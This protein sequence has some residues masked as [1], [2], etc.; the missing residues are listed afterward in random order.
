VHPIDPSP[1]ALQSGGTQ[2]PLFAIADHDVAA[3]MPLAQSLT[4][5]PLYG[6]SGV[7]RTTTVAIETLAE[8]YLPAIR[9][10]QPRGPYRLVGQGIGG[11]IAYDLAYRLL[12]NDEAVEFLAL[13]DTPRPSNT[14]QAD[15]GA[16]QRYCAQPLPIPL[17]LFA[18]D[19]QAMADSWCEFAG[20]FCYA[21]PV[22]DADGIFSATLA[23]KLQEVLQRSIATVPQSRVATYSA[24]LTIQTGR[25]AV[26]PIYC[27][28]G[29]GANITSYLP[30]AQALG[31][32]I[33]LHGLQPRGLDGSWVPHAS[34]EAAAQAY[35]AELKGPALRLVGHSFGGWVAFELAC[36]LA[37][38]G[39]SI[40]SIALLDT[41]PPHS[42][43]VSRY[44][45][46]V[47]TL[48]QLIHIVEQANGVQ[49]AITA[50]QLR[51]LG[52]EAQL[53]RLLAAMKS[54]RLL[55][56]ATRIDAIRNLVRVFSANVH[57]SY[58]PAQK[59]AGC[60]LLLQARDCE[61]DAGEMDND[62]AA[63]TWR[64]YAAS[65]EQVQTPGNHMTMLKEPN[66][67]AVAAQLRAFWN[68]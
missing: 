28:P 19:G 13:I 67:A 26:K 9:R 62:T 35:A 38:L 44:R 30:L 52:Y 55:P 7:D 33:P 60:I 22:I 42:S 47:D 4:D 31:T 59:F 20:K 58:V 29:A 17:H 15:N 48:L 39:H 64:H 51:A 8:N 6:F 43:L 46:R 50:A 14:P 40:E 66:I 37:A 45:G 21:I 34:V 11:L 1:L 41:Q 61:A 54:A 16:Y 25:A 3:F 49:L 2:A 24:K 5:L 27:I 65:V 18:A 68:Y 12:G 63:A 53:A 56:P 32:D 57:T 10:L 23:C 36:Q